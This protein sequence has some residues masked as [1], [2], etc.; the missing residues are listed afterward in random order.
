[1]KYILTIAG[2][3]LI[4]LTAQTQITLEHVDYTTYSEVENVI[5]NPSINTIKFSTIDTTYSYVCNE[6]VDTLDYVNLNPTPDTFGE[7]T[8]NFNTINIVYVVCDT[9][10]NYLPIISNSTISTFLDFEIF[11]IDD[12]VHVAYTE[13]NG[14]LYI[15][16]FETGNLVAEIYNVTSTTVSNNDTLYYSTESSTNPNNNPGNTIFKVT[17]IF[18]GTSEALYSTN[19]EHIN[20]FNFGYDDTEVYVA[21]SNGLYS[22]TNCT[23]ENPISLSIED[24]NILEDVTLYPNPTKSELNLTSLKE[25]TFYQILDISGKVLQNGNTNDKIDVLNLKNGI[26]F[27]Q[28]DGFRT[29]K[30]IKQ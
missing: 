11:I 25:N 21:T 9:N 18:N 1:M 13:P 20:S 3:L 17:D 4:S 29:Q 7:Y 14:N 30:F 24:D 22:N 23:P 5:Y 6:Y 10:T 26:Y 12:S 28:I 16:N 19:N 27:L 2:I 15:Y 8:L